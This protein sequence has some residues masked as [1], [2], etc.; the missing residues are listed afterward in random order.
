MENG[1]VNNKKYFL[2]MAFNGYNTGE[3]KK[4]NDIMLLTGITKS[5]VGY[6]ASMNHN[7]DKEIWNPNWIGL[8]LTDTGMNLAIKFEGMHDKIFRLG[9][10]FEEVMEKA[11]DKNFIFPSKGIRS[12][13]SLE[14]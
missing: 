14:P 2:S 11:N 4:L 9:I 7:G 6:V 5:K 12:K 13:Y 8:Y 1:N 3:I 10:E